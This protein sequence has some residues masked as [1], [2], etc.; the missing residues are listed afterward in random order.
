MPFVFD[1]ENPKKNA[2]EVSHKWIEIMN[3]KYPGK[4]Q[5]K[6]TPTVV[7]IPKKKVVVV[8]KK[9]LPLESNQV[10][11]PKKRNQPKPKG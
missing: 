8:S 3:T 7:V 9:D 6:K 10:S 5:E 11:V 2:W 1:T 4:Y